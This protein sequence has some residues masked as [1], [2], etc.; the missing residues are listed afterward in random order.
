MSSDILFSHSKE[1]FIDIENLLKEKYPNEF[2]LKSQEKVGID[3]LQKIN[4]W[5]KFYFCKIWRW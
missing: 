4:V 5:R 2:T 3:F 1:I